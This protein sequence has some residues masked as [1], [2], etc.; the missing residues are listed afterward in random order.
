[1]T[2]RTR[3][4]IQFGILIFVGLLLFLF[5]PRAA[6]F[7]EMAAR[8]IRHLWWLILLLALAVWF[9]WGVGRKPKE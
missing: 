2:P 8:E 5:F 1:M 9:I 3:A 4:F 7:A 6:A